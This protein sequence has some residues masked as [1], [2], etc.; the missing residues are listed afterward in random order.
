M[1]S[2][3]IHD[4][5]FLLTPIGYSSTPTRRVL[6]LGRAAGPSSTTTTTRICFSW[7]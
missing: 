3:V 1:V 7:N 4:P 2:I 5:T 6:V